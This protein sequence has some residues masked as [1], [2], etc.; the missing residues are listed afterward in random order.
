M[1]KAEIST[2][3]KPA[4]MIVG[5]DNFT[6]SFLKEALL[7]NGCQVVEGGKVDYLFDLSGNK[8]TIGQSLI[9]ARQNQAR[10]LILI[11]KTKPIENMDWIN[12]LDYQE[13]RTVVVKDVYGPR[14]NLQDNQPLN[15]L[16]KGMLG[17]K[18]TVIYK[19]GKK[20]IS[21]TFVADVVYGLIKII[22]SSDTRGGIYSLINQSSVNLA[23]VYQEI[24]QIGLSNTKVSFRPAKKKSTT[25]VI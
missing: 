20:S 10:L 14:M 18:K 16:I 6:G 7:V 3:E 25:S 11:D 13:L 9:I 4:V 12:N 24:V 15:Q 21:P 22:F 8:E 17:K 19:D 1:L 2:T 23:F 5:N